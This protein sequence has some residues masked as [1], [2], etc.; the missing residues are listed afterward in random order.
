[1]AMKTLSCRTA[2][3]ALLAITSAGCSNALPIPLPTASPTHLPESPTPL[4]ASTNYPGSTPTTQPYLFLLPTKSTN[5]IYQYELP[6]WVKNPEANLVLFTYKSKSRAQVGFLNPMDGAQVIVNL[7]QKADNYFWEDSSHIVFLQGPCGDSLEKITELDLSQN[8]L[9]PVAFN[10]FPESI[11]D[12]YPSIDSDQIILEI[13]ESLAEPTLVTLNRAEQWLKVTNPNDGISDISFTISP[14]KD[15]VAIVQIKGKFQFPDL[16]PQPLFGTQVSI[17]HLPD[18]K[19]ITTFTENEKIYS[20]LLF[21]NEN[22]LMYVSGNTP[23]VVNISTLSRE[24]F[25]S[26][27]NKFPNA[28]IILD[29][30]SNDHKRFSF[31]YFQYSP[32]QGG[33]CFYDLSIDNID[34][35]TDQFEILK[36]KIVSTYAVSPDNKYILIEYDYE[37]CPPPWCDYAGDPQ[38][39]LIDI[40]KNTLNKLGSSSEYQALGYFQINL[41]WRPMP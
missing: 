32:Q 29:E 39:G 18:K 35:P 3:L 41:P 8:S 33:L 36:G 24:C 17:Y 16:W 26:I 30:P 4:V 2:C 40:Q 38:L 10:E 34:C 23:C 21:N 14:D 7:P 6:E 28:T 1:M 12:C 15:Y 20:S 9:Q 13:D 31:I 11:L 5:G 19:L 22:D 27:P 25:N 37:G